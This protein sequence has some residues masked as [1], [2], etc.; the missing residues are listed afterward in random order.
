MCV[1]VC[2]HVCMVI[3]YCSRVWINWVRLTILLVVSWAGK[4]KYFP[5][6]VRAWEFGLIRW[7]QASRPA[8]VCSFS[9][10]WIC[11]LL[12]GFLPISAAAS[13]YFLKPPHAIGTAQS[14]SGHAIAYRWH[15]LPSV[16]RH[17]ASSPQSGSSRGC[18]LCISMGSNDNVRLSFPRPTIYWYKVSMQVDSK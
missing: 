9:S 17:R 18:C 1:L 11:W 5:L 15:S 3:I 13:I 4:I 10:G 16:R 6:P 8:S 12:T 7:I 14:L 2:V